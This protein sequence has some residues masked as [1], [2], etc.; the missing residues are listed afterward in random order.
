MREI[1]QRIIQA[2][3]DLDN[4]LWGSFDS[5]FGNAKQHANN[6]YFYQTDLRNAFGSVSLKRLADILI[7]L[8]PKWELEEVKEILD[9]YCF[10]N[11]GKGLIVGAPASPKLFE[12]YAQQIIDVPLAEFWP[13]MV[14]GNRIFKKQYSRY[15][16]DLTFSSP[17]PITDGVRRMIRRIIE[18]SGFQVNHRKSVVLDL[19]KGRLLLLALDWNIA[20]AEVLGSFCLVTTSNG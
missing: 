13:Y 1:H 10:E 7:S 18:Q 8:E 12:I 19:K 6:R 4:W 20:I 11:G 2:V 15:T 14:D 3:K 9:C 5:P 17:E 16:D